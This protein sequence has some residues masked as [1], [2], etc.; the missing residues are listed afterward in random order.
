[1]GASSH[2]EDVAARYSKSAEAYLRHWAPVLAPAGRQLVAHL[3]IAEA[4]RV[5]DL[6]TGVGTLLPELALA[7][8]SATV[9]GADR[10][11]G[12]VRLAPAAFPRV[13]TDAGHIC[14][15]DASFD[16]VVA[17]FMLFHLLEPRAAL[18]EVRRVLRERGVVAISTW[19]A[20]EGESLADTVWSEELDRAG[21]APADPA[22]ASHDQMDSRHKLAALLTETGFTDVQTETAPVTDAPDVEEF[23]GRRTQL[24]LSEIRFR[25]LSNPAQ[26]RFLETVRGR[27]HELKPEGLTTRDVAVLAWARKPPP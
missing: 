8:P 23:L 26:T 2:T 7:A 6:G 9:V 17:A 11:E 15:R 27:L 22:P 16:A 24:G 12:M 19:E 1:M 14:F 5:L 13:V 10:A 25:S 21:A 3:D 18:L 4:R 20:D